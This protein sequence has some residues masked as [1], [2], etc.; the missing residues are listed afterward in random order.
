MRPDVK[1]GIVFSM[2]IVLVAGG[3]YMYRDQ[4]E[5]PIPLAGGPKTKDKSS[6][7]KKKPTAPVKTADARKRPAPR[8][9]SNEAQ[10][11]PR[12]GRQTPAVAK[13]SPARTPRQRIAK[14]PTTAPQSNG[15]VSPVPAG[16]KTA[17]TPV[18][19]ADR[20]TGQRPETPTA[21]PVEK[22]PSAPGQKSADEKL[23]ALSRAGGEQ[24]TSR[25]DATEKPTR[26]PVPLVGKRGGSTDEPVKP[27]TG[28][29]RVAV[30]THRVQPGDT[31][32]ALAESYYGS[33]KYT[34]FL[35][36]SNPQIEYPDRL[37]VGMT[38]KIPERP[39]GDPANRTAVPRD[40]ASARGGA[41][42]RTYRVQ[43]GDTFYGIAQKQL[44]DA[45]RWEELFELNKDVVGGNAKRL[46]V[47]HVLRLPNQ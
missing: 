7:A 16:Q 15:A 11:R 25:G 36:E 21:R 3:Y 14:A 44:G 23:A 13:R 29:A 24:P 39:T 9:K 19:V 27:K 17:K 10:V 28:P 32:S 26:R 43:S 47:G 45:S 5:S 40:P 8:R 4:S 37:R 1:L 2:M 34:Q 42:Y 46:Q 6:V 33:A 41:K 35:I 38:V 22:R 31:M 12:T 30:E 18:K 20:S